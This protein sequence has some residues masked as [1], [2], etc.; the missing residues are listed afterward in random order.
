LELNPLGKEK[1]CLAS[2]VIAGRQE[3]PSERTQAV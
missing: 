1:I 3:Q 2:I